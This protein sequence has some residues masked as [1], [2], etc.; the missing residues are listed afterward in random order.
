MFGIFI[1]RAA[2]DYYIQEMH[3]DTPLQDGYY[4]C[5]ESFPTEQEAKDCIAQYREQTAIY[6]VFFNRPA[7]EGFV[8]QEDNFSGNWRGSKYNYYN[9]CGEYKTEEEAKSRLTEL[10]SS[11]K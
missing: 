10:Y 6:C 4:H 9:L 11:K 2:G 8:S 7:W 3:S 1:N 5:V